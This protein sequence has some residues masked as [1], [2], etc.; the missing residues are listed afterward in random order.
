VKKKA[1]RSPAAP[2]Q[3]ERERPISTRGFNFPR[4]RRPHPRK[5]EFSIF[6]LLRRLVLTFCRSLLARA[7]NTLNNAAAY[8]HYLHNPTTGN[9]TL[10]VGEM[11]ELIDATSCIAFL[12]LRRG[13]GLCEI[14]SSFLM[15]SPQKTW[16]E[17][18]P[19]LLLVQT[20]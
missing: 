2:P 8:I 10:L 18:A 6:T 5:L 11:R 1:T 16:R 3:R 19:I 13:D 15:T 7:S 4:V 20:Q 17:P 12:Y 9:T 14:A